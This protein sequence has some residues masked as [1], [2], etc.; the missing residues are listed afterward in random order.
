MMEGEREA[1]TRYKEIYRT[2]NIFRSRRC[3]SCNAFLVFMITQR[4]FSVFAETPTCEYRSHIF[5]P[6]M[7]SKCSP[8]T[9]C[10]NSS[11]TDHRTIF[12]KVRFWRFFRYGTK[13][14]IFA[15]KIEF[16]SAVS[17]QNSLDKL[18]SNYMRHYRTFA[19]LTV[20]LRCVFRENMDFRGCV[21]FYP[22]LY[23]LHRTTNSHTLCENS[24]SE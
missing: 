24:L 1:K 13:C 11:I 21:F 22:L 6:T 17:N 7:F 12:G 19:P 14:D 10:R 2:E 9:Q 23:I 18:W 4:Q 16:L 3:K 5:P 20:G 8:A 15:P